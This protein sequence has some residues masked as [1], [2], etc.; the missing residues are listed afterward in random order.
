MKQRIVIA[1]LALAAP[2]L[3]WGKHA[4]PWQLNMTQG[5]TET[6]TCT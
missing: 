5:V 4:E 1:L 3:A 6:T 2:A